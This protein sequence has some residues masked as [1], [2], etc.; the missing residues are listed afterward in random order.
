V[1]GVRAALA[2][3]TP[4][5][6]AARPDRRAVPWFAV[7]GA[8]LGACVAG[9]WWGLAQ[10]LP[11]PVA[12]AI[13]VATDVVLTGGL[14]LDGLADSADGLLPPV[15]RERRLAIMSDPHVG[16]F[17][18]IALVTV[19]LIRAAVLASVHPTGRTVLLVAA[20]WA[21]SRAAMGVVATTLPYARPN[22]LATAFTG[23]PVGPVLAVGTPLA[24]VLAVLGGEP[25]VRGIVI[26]LAAAVGAALVTTFARA[27][28]GGFTGDVL[29]AAGVIGETVALVVLAART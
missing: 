23:G 20:V 10:V 5:G 4:I 16:A 18:M 9:V 11:L 6:G 14:H 15:S 21:T 7:V 3:L 22:G 26:V 25:P 12:G 13:A 28:L 29:G 27:R 17:G 8:L 2:F 1:T 24:L 19:L